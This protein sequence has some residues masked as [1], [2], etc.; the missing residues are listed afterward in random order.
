MEGLCG[1]AN[2]MDKKHN[3]FLSL[4]DGET[5]V[6]GS[7]EKQ[8]NSGN[9]AF[10][11][12]RP[13]STVALGVVHV[14]IALPERSVGEVVVVTGRDTVR[15]VGDGDQGVCGISR[16]CCLWEVFKNERFCSSRQKVGISRNFRHNLVTV[17]TPCQRGRDQQCHQGRCY[18][19]HVGN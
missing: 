17:A 10:A 8:L 5:D 15:P 13:I 3:G 16:F 1:V 9:E 12:R 18:P 19:S 2:Q 7:C 6:C 11:S 4:M 14:P